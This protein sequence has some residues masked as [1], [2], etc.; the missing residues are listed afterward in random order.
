MTFPLWYLLIPYALIVFGTGLFL[1][2]NLYHVGKFSVKSLGTTLLL[3]SYLVSYVAV[4]IVSL[5]VLAGYDW[6]REVSV[7]D[8][9]PFAG[10]SVGNANFGL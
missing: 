6:Q 3:G 7:G 2:F 4:L 9:F 1:F 5:T 8:V 10:E